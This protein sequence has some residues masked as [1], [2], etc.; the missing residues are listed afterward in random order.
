M[1][2]PKDLPTLTID[3]DA[4]LPLLE[5]EDI[6]DAQKRELIEALWSIVV[7]FVDLS[8]GIDR[9]TEICG[10]DPGDVAAAFR[11]VAR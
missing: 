2:E 10:Q 4:Y 3:W 9:T 11:D 5:S 7:T 8:F 1:P 6:S